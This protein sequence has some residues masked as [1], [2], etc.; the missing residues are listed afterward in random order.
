VPVITLTGDAIIAHNYGDVYTDQGATATDNVDALVTVTVTGGVTI[1]AVNSYTI[2]YTATDAAGNEATPVVRAVNVDDLAGPVITLNGDSNIILGQGRDYK[3]LGASALD[4]FDNEAIDILAPSEGTVDNSTIGEYRLTYT[5]TD[6]KGQQTSIVRTVNIVEPR[7]FIT[8]WRTDKP[9]ESDDFTIRLDIPYTPNFVT[10]DWGDGTT[11]TE[12]NTLTHTYT[13]KGTYTITISG[14]F[15]SLD[16]DY[17]PGDI[18][19]IS[20]LVSVEQWGDV[21]WLS[22]GR[23]FAGCD[24][25]AFNA[26]DTPDLRQVTNMFGA[27]SY[28]TNITGNLS[29]WEFSSGTEMNEMF[30][31][32]SG[33]NVD[34][35]SWDVSQV[36]DMHYMFEDVGDFNQDISAWDVSS[37]TDMFHMFKNAGDFN[38]DISAW[39]V[40]S[41]RDME[42]MFI[43]ASTFDQDLSAWDVSSVRY[44]EGMFSGATLSSENYDALLN[45]WSQQQVQIGINFHGGNSMPT[46]NS[47]DAKAILTSAPNYWTIYD[48]ST[49]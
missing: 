17:E 19:D 29:G 18:R 16:Y 6:S 13:E 2:T 4:A 34:I 20:K 8:T 30:R 7:P 10:V 46:E 26:S 23:A 11:S 44:M 36:T 42:G 24:N 21:Q 1:D 39:D 3:E 38:Q 43:G 35:T 9:G 48:G 27:F 22:M 31:G 15:R 12:R 49:P 41:V 28:C 25:V 32:A 37:V 33:I 45:S 40:S 14:D 5:A 47:A